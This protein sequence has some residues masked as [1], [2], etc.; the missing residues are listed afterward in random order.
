MTHPQGLSA[1]IRWLAS[2][3]VPGNDPIF[4]LDNASMLYASN[5][6]VANPPEPGNYSDLKLIA[7]NLTP[8]G[9]TINLQQIVAIPLP[10]R[11]APSIAVIGLST[12]G[13]VYMLEGRRWRVQGSAPP[14]INLP[15]R[16]WK[17]ISRHTG[18]GGGATF[19][20][21]TNEVWRTMTGTL[22]AQGSVVWSPPVK[23]SELRVS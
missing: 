12:S 7:E 17:S 20:T 9:Q 2:Y 11:F 16:T 5:G 18:P 8:L 3:S 15:S 13:I 10:S 19:L 6:L 21:T 14:L 1:G 4:V 23:A 22:D